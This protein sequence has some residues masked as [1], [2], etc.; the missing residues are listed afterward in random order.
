[1][2]ETWLDE[3]RDAEIHIDGYQIYRSD[4]CVKRTR[5]RGKERG[6]VALYLRD[7]LTPLTKILLKYSNGAVDILVLHVK[8]LNS[9][10]IVIYRHPDDPGGRIRSTANQFAWA[11]DRV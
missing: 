11:L 2:S 3:H 1:M 10:I 8:K 7:D 4:C 6:G 5:N 9:I